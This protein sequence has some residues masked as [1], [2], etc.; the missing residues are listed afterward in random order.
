MLQHGWILERLYYV[1]KARPK[2]HILYDSIVGNV[3]SRQ[4]H[5]YRKLISGCRGAAGERK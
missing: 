5:T 4:I 1:K 2:G 3:H